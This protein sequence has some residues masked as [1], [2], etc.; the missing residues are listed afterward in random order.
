MRL[1]L[2][3]WIDAVTDNHGWRP[4]EQVRKGVPS[5]CQTVGWI[6]KQTKTYITLVA[7]LG[8]DDCDGDIT[9]PIGM[10]KEI[11]PLSKTK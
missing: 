6:I 10:I 7:T 4:L 1:V 9:I 8:E 3:K 2:V 11:I 5:R